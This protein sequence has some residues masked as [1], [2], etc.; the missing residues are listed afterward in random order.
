MP[1]YPTPLQKYIFLILI[2]FLPFP[3]MAATATSIDESGVVISAPQFPTSLEGLYPSDKR[4]FA[5]EGGFV[6]DPTVRETV[7][8]FYSTVY[9]SS[10]G[11]PSDWNGDVAS[12]TAGNT[13]SAYQS[14]TRRR[15]NWYR[16]MAGI[17]ASI[18]FDSGFNIKA[19]QAALIMSANNNLSHN[20]P[21]SWT[22]YT[23]DGAQA[24]GKSNLALGSAGPDAIDAYIED[25]GSS[26][27]LVG[28]RRWILY[29]QT[30]T[31]G[32]GDVVSTSS[33]YNR[34]NSLWVFD[35]NIWGVRPSVRDNFIAWPPKGYVPYQ[36][37]HPR[38]SISYPS[39]DFSNATVT[40]N[41]NGSSITVTKETYATGYGENTLVWRPSPYT[42]GQ[43]WV[44]PTADE[45][46]QVTVGNVLVNNQP[47]TFS[48]TVTIFDPSVKGSDYT[49]QSI[50]G[51]SSIPNGQSTTYTFSPVP[52][53]NSYQWRQGSATNYTTINGAE[54][55]LGDFLADG[56]SGYSPISTGSPSTGSAAYHL[57][58]P[59]P[60]VD[61]TLTLTKTLFVGA[62]SNLQFDSRL[63]YA[64]PNQY[65]MVEASEDEGQSWITLY[66]QAGS[67]S[68]GESSYSAKSVPLAGFS[69]K[70]IMLRFR[71][72]MA[73]GSYYNGTSDNVGWLFDN[74]QVTDSQAA[75]FS[76][77]IATNTSSSFI[78]NS[79]TAGRY[80]LQVRPVLFGDYPGEW[81]AAKRVDVTTDSCGEGIA[82]T[83]GQWQMLALPCVPDP[84]TAS[85]ANVFGNSPT[86][87]LVAST[88]GTR[89]MI[90]Q[91]NP[92]NT[93]N[94]AMTQASMFSS[95][96]GYWIKSYDAPVNGKLKIVAGTATPVQTGI[97]GCQS[98]QGCAVVS[99]P[100]GTAGPRMIGNPFPYHVDWSKVRVRVGGSGG[101]IYT[102]SAAS[103]ATILDKQIWI[104]NGTSYETWDDSIDPGNLQYFKAFFVKVLASGVGQTLELLIPAEI[105]N[106]TGALPSGLA[107]GLAS[108]DSVSRS[109][110]QSVLD[111][112]VPSATAA[113]S[114]ESRESRIP[115]D[116]GWK[117]R[118]RVENLTTGAKARA[119][120]GQRP[121][122]EV[123]YDSADLSA[124]APFAAPYLTLVFPQ[125]TW[126]TRKGDYA[127][128]FRPADGAPNQW[129]LELR[130][131]PVGKTVVMLRWEGDPAVLARS[132]LVDTQTGTVITPSVPP[133][134]NGY[135][136]TLTTPV[137]RLTWE[138]L[139]Q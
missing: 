34:A 104:W 2:Y 23:A 139:G 35:N 16:A 14:A 48:Y 123:G 79:A 13:S 121:G 8:L 107:E 77:P 58:H 18:V 57:A 91:R 50:T 102:P 19:Q 89:W 6:I 59:T 90:Y 116:A 81:S 68:S 52:I 39:A 44:K 15:V 73:G 108:N 70:T 137:R 96:A 36:T 138:Y 80:L 113:E 86:A 47:Q 84:A 99:V 103:T 136:L 128:D 62:T 43:G 127:S 54:S 100:T 40:I 129:N 67:N 25:Y 12:C 126:D 101:T 32:T 22:C 114:R 26:N 9:L 20:P 45:T 42:D 98:A 55:G 111:W 88:Y 132:R 5:V 41:R 66:E 106:L 21:T 119:L 93:G 95:G 122:A 60:P 28:H 92:T 124:M 112:L 64:M 31:M 63:G 78:F 24:A 3:I 1:R 30:Q 46:Y 97:T 115:V 109:W 82:L 83:P 76:T 74:V 61:Q 27:N 133:Y 130:S 56:S 65:A 118:L 125:L 11:V 131:A 134:V 75:S 110:S 105:S 51:S 87:N 10:A 38:W 49:P 37:V 29:P 17:P 69:G 7:R 117:V 71:Y 94:A 85:V 53:A 120:L 135:R 72:R 4:P 33:S